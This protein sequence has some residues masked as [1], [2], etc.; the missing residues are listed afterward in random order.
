LIQQAIK[1]GAVGYVV[2]SEGQQL[3]NAIEAILRDGFY[4]GSTAAYT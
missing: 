3:L 4:A 2:K 1:A